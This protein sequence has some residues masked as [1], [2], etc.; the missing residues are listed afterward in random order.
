M[1]KIHL[2]AEGDWEAIHDFD[3]TG[4]SL[5]VSDELMRKTQPRKATVD[6]EIE[7]E[8]WLSR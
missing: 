8:N 7:E 3:F 1:S 2:P 5:L 4:K 6:V